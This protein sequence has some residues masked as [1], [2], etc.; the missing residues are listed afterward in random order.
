MTTN[1]LKFDDLIKRAKKG[2]NEDWD[3]VDTNL[4]G[5]LSFEYVDWAL[6]G[7]LINPDGNVRDLAAT[8]LARSDVEIDP[9]DLS[10]MAGFMETDPNDFVRHWLANALYKR[11]NRSGLTVLLVKEASEKDTPAGE[12]ARNLR[13]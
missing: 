3:F 12:F 1:T 7:G 8:L 9:V 10:W 6:R 5:F 13:K 2:T 4:S 11:G